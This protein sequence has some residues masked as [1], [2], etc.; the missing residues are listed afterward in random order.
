MDAAKAIELCK[1]ASG[2]KDWGVVSAKFTK[3]NGSPASVSQQVGV[4]PKF[5]NAITPRA[6]DNLF[7]ISSGKARTVGQSDACNTCTCD[8]AGPQGSAPSGFPQ[9]NGC[10]T[11]PDIFFDSFKTL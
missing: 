1:T 11:S 9:D 4:M 7:V 2:P 6:G 10:G 5:G 3:A 8:D